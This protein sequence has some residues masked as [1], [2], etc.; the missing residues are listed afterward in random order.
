LTQRVVEEYPNT[1]EN[2]FRYRER[3]ITV[4]RGDNRIR[5]NGAIADSAFISM[6]GFPTEA[7]D[8]MYGLVELQSVI[9]TAKTANHFFWHLPKQGCRELSIK[10]KVK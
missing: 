8:G 6:F 5:V 1:F 7:G 2:Y 10:G 4:A 3:S 9:V